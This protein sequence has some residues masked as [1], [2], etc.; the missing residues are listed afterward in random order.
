MRV[1]ILSPS[2]VFW[3]FWAPPVE[4]R[5]T[6]WENSCWKRAFL[7]YRHIIC[8]VSDAIC[9]ILKCTR[10]PQSVKSVWVIIEVNYTVNNLPPPRCLTKRPIARYYRSESFNELVSV[11]DSK[12]NDDRTGSGGKGG[13]DA[14]CR[15]P[16]RRAIGGWPYLAAWSWPWW[17]LPEVSAAKTASAMSRFRLVSHFRRQRYLLSHRLNVNSR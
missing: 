8:A 14:G 5:A 13:L 4:N 9:H 11:S 2:W 16:Q 15:L 7:P 6:L 12:W 3:L 1:S 17:P 10:W